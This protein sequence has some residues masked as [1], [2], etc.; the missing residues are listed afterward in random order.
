M[1]NPQAEGLTTPG[2][3]DDETDDEQG[4]EGALHTTWAR[5]A[6]APG[7][8]RAPFTLEQ[9]ASLN[10][11]QRSGAFHPFTCAVDSR[12]GALHATAGG[13]HCRECHY[14]QHWAH[15][16]MADGSWALRATP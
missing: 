15:R 13:W 16:W 2:E 11:Y 5:D 1:S 10:D 4:A 6:E 12:H 14:A 8:V 9:V 3:T 7:Y